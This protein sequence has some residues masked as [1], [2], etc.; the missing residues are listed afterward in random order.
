MPTPRIHDTDAFVLMA[1]HFAI[2]CMLLV[3]S[4]YIHIHEGTGISRLG[5]QSR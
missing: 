3:S 5:I 4:S 1:C 2:L